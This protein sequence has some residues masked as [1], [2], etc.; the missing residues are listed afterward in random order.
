MP[1]LILLGDS[2]LDNGAYTNGQPPVIDQLR[3]HLPAGWKAT[4]AA[5]DG[6]TTDDIPTQLAGLPGDATHLVLS[7][8][9]NDAMLRADEGSAA[10]GAHAR[11]HD[12]GVRAEHLAQGRQQL[13]LTVASLRARIG[14]ADVRFRQR[15]HAQSFAG[16][17]TC[18][19]RERQ[20][21]ERRDRPWFE[22]RPSP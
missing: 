5:I 2:I 11:I 6:S 4:L 3:G 7:I 16:R 17:S 12:V 13:P 21:V 18:R 9:G 19:H 1:H 8:G 15:S 14:G 22:A 10:P 20:A